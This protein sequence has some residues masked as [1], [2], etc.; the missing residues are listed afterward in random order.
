MT[1][2][3]LITSDLRARLFLKVWLSIRGYSVTVCRSTTAARS[4]LSRSEFSAVIVDIHRQ[5]ENAF[6]FVKSTRRLGQY[7]PTLFLGERSYRELLERGCSG[8]DEFVLKPIKLRGFNE[9]LN[10]VLRIDERL[11]RIALD[12]APP[13]R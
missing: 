11:G 4:E 1:K 3:L 2:L 7:I 9:A 12:F 5:E 6:A 10:V 8:L 13:A